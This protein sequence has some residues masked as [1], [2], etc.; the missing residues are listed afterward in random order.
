MEFSYRFELC[1]AASLSE[2][3]RRMLCKM[4][5]SQAKDGVRQSETFVDEHCEVCVAAQFLD[6]IRNSLPLCGGSERE[7]Q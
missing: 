1:V 4:T 5:A 6:D 2:D 7:P 3:F